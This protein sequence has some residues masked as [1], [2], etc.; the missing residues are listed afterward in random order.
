MGMSAMAKKLGNAISICF[1]LIFV[2]GAN[3]NTP[4]MTKMGAVE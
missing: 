3:I 2:T 4:T 1:Q